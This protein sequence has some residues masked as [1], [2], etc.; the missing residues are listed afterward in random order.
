MT[1][2]DWQPLARTC[3]CHRREYRVKDGKAETRK[4]EVTDA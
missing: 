4:I 3:G 1:D 2:T